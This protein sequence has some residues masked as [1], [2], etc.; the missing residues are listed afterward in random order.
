MSAATWVSI[1]GAKIL[2]GVAR[3][4][5]TELLET[6]TVKGTTWA[7]WKP[8]LY[9]ADGMVVED[10]YVGKNRRTGL[11]LAHA[12]GRIT[13]FGSVV[14]CSTL[15]ML[16]SSTWRAEVKIRPNAKR[17]AQKQAARAMC[18]WLA[19]EPAGRKAATGKAAH[20]NAWH[21]PSL[22]DASID[23]CEAVLLGLAYM[24]LA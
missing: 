8:V 11:V 22:L 20:W 5:G 2:S 15:A 14:G 1:D 4:R 9:G 17:E 19:W 16:Q 12:R 18:N 7:A 3:W 6:F 10:G 23:E 13:A 24:R 21:L